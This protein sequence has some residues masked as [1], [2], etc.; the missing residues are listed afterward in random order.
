MKQD[1]GLF[2]LS[3]M[4]HTLN[5]RPDQLTRNQ[6]YQCQWKGVGKVWT[7]IKIFKKTGWKRNDLVRLRN[8]SSKKTGKL[9]NSPVLEETNR[10]LYADTECS[11]SALGNVYPVSLD[12]TWNMTIAHLLSEV[13]SEIF[14]NQ[15]YFS[16]FPKY[17][18]PRRKIRKI[19]WKHHNEE[20]PL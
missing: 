7:L 17:L 6:M 16:F 8:L 14:R 15:I 1:Y 4:H 12:R 9:R 10:F 5:S 2:G 18:N 19:W 13:Y 3:K 20:C 11:H